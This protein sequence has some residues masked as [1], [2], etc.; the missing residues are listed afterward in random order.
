[1]YRRSRSQISAKAAPA[2]PPTG[3]GSTETESVLQALRRRRTYIDPAHVADALDEIE[4]ELDSGAV[5]LMGSLMGVMCTSKEALCA[6]L[7]GYT[8]KLNPVLLSD[9]LTYAPQYLIKAFSQLVYDS[10]LQRAVAALFPVYDVS[11]RPTAVSILVELGCCT[12]AVLESVNEHLR[13]LTALRND[14]IFVSCSVFD[15][16]AVS[17]L[18]DGHRWCPVQNVAL[19]EEWPTVRSSRTRGKSHMR[20]HEVPV[21]SRTVAPAPVSIGMTTDCSLRDV[22][23]DEIR[24]IHAFRRTQTQVPGVSV[25]VY[26]NGIDT[27]SDRYSVSEVANMVTSAIDDGWRFTVTPCAPTARSFAEQFGVR[28]DNPVESVH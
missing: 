8:Q 2:V 6:S 11:T 13:S 27:T 25:Y 16:D 5:A 10:P 15:T 20:L 18:P 1:M 3:M 23:G 4:T 7:R 17:L 24:S 19:L 12:P 22:L 26:C 14:A 9:L 21:V 28:C